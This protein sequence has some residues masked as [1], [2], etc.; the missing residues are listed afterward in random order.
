MSA[1][2]LDQSLDEIL[3][4]RR[5][6]KTRGRR[7]GPGGKATQK[8]APVGGVKKHTKTAKPNKAIPTGPANA[9][10][11]SKIIVS[12]LP[13]DVDEN[14]I[15]EYFSKTIGSIKKVMLTYGPNGQSRGICTI[16]FGRPNA[17]VEAAK[18]LDGIKIDNRPMKIEVILSAKDA[19]T[20]AGPK[21]LADRMSL[22]KKEKPQPKPAT[23]TRNLRGANAGRGRGAKRGGGRGGRV[24]ARIPKKTVEELDAEMADYFEPIASTGDGDAMQ[25]NGGAV[26]ATGGGDTGMGEDE[27]L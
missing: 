8:D 10:G 4:T 17:A 25:T 6:T 26:Q 1:A 20:V 27:M 22:P 16:I 12:N 11:D 13:A 2:K 3:K 24:G 19:P 15:K 7:N 18:Q 5:N 21:S 23:N 14:Q 9:S